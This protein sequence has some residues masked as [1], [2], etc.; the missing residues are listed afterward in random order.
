MNPISYTEN[1]NKILKKITSAKWIKKY[2]MNKHM[3]YKSIKGPKFKD[4]F[5]NQLSSKD[6]SAKSTLAL[7]QFM[8]DSL[9][10]H[11]SPDNWLL[12]LYQYTLKKNFPE[13]VT[14]KMIP[15]LTAPCELYLAIFNTICSI[16]KNSGDGT[17]ESRYLQK[18]HL[19]R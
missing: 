11:K 13:N 5:K 3:I 1:Y 19:H 16:Q 9:S 8:M 12:Y 6:F 15:Q 18:S 17:W 2:N 7:C 4:A 14:V 10:G